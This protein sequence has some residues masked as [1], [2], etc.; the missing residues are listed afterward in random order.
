MTERKLTEKQELFL[1]YLFGDAEGVAY[2]AK[3]MAGYSPEYATSL[4]VKSVEDE[5]LERTKR[6]LVENGPKAAKAVT[7]V[8]DDPAQIGVG[9]KLQAA[10]EILDRI[11]IVRTDKIEATPGAFILPPKD[12]K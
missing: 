5:I 4:L 8:L 7:G 10:K 3:V 2:K 9:Y 1:F 12:E 11:G 6:Y